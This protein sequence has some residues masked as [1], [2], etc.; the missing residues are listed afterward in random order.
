MS[1]HVP[2]ER[3]RQSQPLLYRP[4][5]L[6][7]IKT[8]A[9]W[10]ITAPGN[11]DGNRTQVFARAGAEVGPTVDCF[12]WGGVVKLAHPSAEQVRRLNPHLCVQQKSQNMQPPPSRYLCCPLLP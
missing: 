4:W 2:F 9:A 11:T 10:P 3:L 7:F 5:P 1:T 8:P 6:R 12:S